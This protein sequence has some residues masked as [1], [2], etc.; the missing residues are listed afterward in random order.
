MTSRVPGVL[1]LVPWSTPS[2]CL[3]CRILGPRIRPNHACRFFLECT[4]SLSRLNQAPTVPSARPALLFARFSR[5][6]LSTCSLL[7][8]KGGGGRTRPLRRKLEENKRHRSSSSSSSQTSLQQHP[9]LDRRGSAKSS[10]SSFDPHPPS[11]LLSL[12]PL[13]YCM[14]YSPTDDASLE[15]KK[16]GPHVRPDA[17]TIVP[18]GVKKVRHVETDDDE[19]SSLNVQISER[20]MSWQRTAVLL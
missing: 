17:E 5:R 4:C 19:D 15:K 1:C 11:S 14:S 20:S 3:P 13:F 7:A 8:S 18:D 9:L 10:F 12:S 2:D 6:L 16:V